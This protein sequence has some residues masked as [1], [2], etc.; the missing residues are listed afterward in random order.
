MMKSTHPPLAWACIPAAV[1]LL[2]SCGAWAEEAQE[3]AELG[4]VTVRGE[5]TLAERLQV[6]NSNE[7]LTRQDLIATVNAMNT[8]DSFKYLPNV[9][10]RKR[11]IGDT[12]A[13]ISSRT[14]GINA[15]ARS[16]VYADGVLLTPLINN[17]NGNGSPR[18]FMVSSE[19]IA[20]VDVLYGPYAAA[21][22]GNSYGLVAN[23]STRMPET[24]EGSVKLGQAWQRFDQYG[25]HD[26]YRSQQLAATLGNRAG[27]FS[28][29]LSA[30]HV[31]SYSMPVT[32]AV[33]PTLQASGGTAITGGISDANRT[34]DRDRS[35]F[36]QI[37]GA[38]NLT[39]TVQDNAKLKLGYDFSPR[40]QAIYSFGVWQ[41]QADLSAQTYLSNTATGAA[42]WGGAS[43][44][45]TVAGQ[46][47]KAS[48]IAALFAPGRKDMEHHMHSL[49]VRDRGQDELSWQALVSSYEYVKHQERTGTTSGSALYPTVAG[50]SGAGKTVDMKGTG[51]YS[52]DL[53]ATWRPAGAHSWSAGLHYDRYK[54]VSPTYNTTGSWLTASN[55]SLS[56]DSRG[57]SETQALWLQDMWQLNP[58]WR[59]TLGARQ[60]WWRAFD[61]SNTASG[62]TVSQPQRS[63][64][65]FSPKASLAWAMRDD[66][67]VSASLG[68]AVRFPTVGELYLTQS[69]GGVL[70]SSDPNLK[71]EN[72]TSG[73][74]A[75]DYALEKGKLRVS[76]F[77]ENVKDA[78]ISQSGSYARISGVTTY[79]QNIDR[80]RQRGLEV[81]WQEQDVGIKGLDLS[82]SVTYVDARI[83]ANSGYVAPTWNPGATSVGKHT[84]YVPDWRATAVATYRPDSQ[85]SYTLAGRY[86]GRMWATVDGSDINANT[87]IGFASFFV[88]DARVRYQMDKHWS[89]ALGVDNL[90]NRKYFLYHPFPQRTLFAELRYEL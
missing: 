44:N 20:R 12:D 75:L 5:K 6:P 36:T 70:Q 23:I 88:L 83:L 80:T 59:A 50:G 55:G 19:E 74:L 35:G 13:P 86:S 52:A 62:S 37:F 1:A 41:N 38:G 29:W 51:W 34:G 46:N 53:S 56:A 7:G 54:L 73:E 90:N 22:P 43:G 79:M 57:Q 30:N 69:V 45:V 17:N 47:Y 32:F 72:V 42:Y 25:T 28:F 3:Q 8:E 84:P 87:Y 63:E 31:D 24:L 60:E 21:Y 4:V 85:W 64:T 39:H 81:V 27:D 82:A 16:L 89:T 77:Q 68:K 66:V 49:L 67:Q 26:S 33:N 58:A 18:W 78:L 2:M 11:F 9:L 61:G 48:D 15:S 65:A 14:T 40:V 76:L 10:V 71:P